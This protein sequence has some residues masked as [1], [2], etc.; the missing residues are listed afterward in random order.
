[1]PL[2]K[3][4]S[5]REAVQTVLIALR[6]LSQDVGIPKNLQELVSCGGEWAD[7]VAMS[8]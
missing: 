4:V 6:Q 7:K 5:E 2:G 1:M 3:D 8:F